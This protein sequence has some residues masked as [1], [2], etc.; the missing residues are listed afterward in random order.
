MI[1]KIPEKRLKRCPAIVHVSITKKCNLNCRKC[2]YKG[3][4]NPELVKRIIRDI[5]ASRVKTVAIG[6]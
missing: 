5:A 1:A 6:G 2:Y 4:E 3:K